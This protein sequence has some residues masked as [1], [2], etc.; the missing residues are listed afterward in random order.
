MSYQTWTT[1]GFGF[2]VTQIA[3]DF[4]DGIDTDLV[5]AVIAAIYEFANSDE[6]IMD[7]IANEHE[8]SYDMIYN[9]LNDKDAAA[10]LNTEQIFYDF[11][12][13]EGEK[14]SVADGFEQL[15][16]D[17]FNYKWC[18]DGHDDIQTAAVDTLG[19]NNAYWMLG[20][21][22]PWHRCE[23]ASQQ[24]C[25]NTIKRCFGKLI[26]NVKIETLCITSD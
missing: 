24:D 8:T 14:F 3:N 13:Y 1:S 7:Y 5:M 22:Y 4:R 17:I 10:A 20:T 6:D 15:L 26:Q 25:E 18:N 16:I 11:A 23:F 2:D 12:E 9:A 19:D 21:V